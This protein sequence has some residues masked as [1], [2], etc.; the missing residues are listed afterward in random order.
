MKVAQVLYGGAEVFRRFKVGATFSN[1]GII[2]KEEGTSVTGGPIP[3]TE[4]DSQDSIGLAQEA[5]IY[6]ATPAI[7][8]TGIITVSIRPDIMI[9][10]LMSGGGTEGTALTTITNTAADLTDPDLITSSDSQANDMTSGTAWRL[11]TEGDEAGELDYWSIVSHSTGTSVTI[12]PDSETGF[13]VNDQFL[14]CP[15]NAV[16]Y[17]GSANVEASTNVNT[18]DLFTEA[19]ATVATGTGLVCVVM[20]LELRSATDSNVIFRQAEHVYLAIS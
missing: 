16:P 13:A 18:S 17:D 2:A 3:S 12:I 5:A 11:Q 7:G 1:P 19:D 8:A 4:T 10:A 20:D 6:S 9:R 15:W 14:M